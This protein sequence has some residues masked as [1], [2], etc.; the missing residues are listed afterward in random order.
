MWNIS[1]CSLVL[2][3]LTGISFKILLFIVCLLGMMHTTVS[4]WYVLLIN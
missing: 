2:I 4:Y 1:L 3:N